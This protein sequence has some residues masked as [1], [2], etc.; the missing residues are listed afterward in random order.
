MSP[1]F[2]FAWCVKRLKAVCAAV[3]RKGGECSHFSISAPATIG[4]ICAVE[5]QLGFPLP[6]NLRWFAENC[7]AGFCVYWDLNDSREK[8]P[9]NL[10]GVSSGGLE[11]SLRELP[12]MYSGQIS[13]ARE[14]FPDTN[15]PFDRLWHYTLCFSPVPNGDLLAIQRQPEGSDSIVYLSHEGDDEH[16]WQMGTSFLDSFMRWCAIGCVGPESWQWSLFCASSRGNIDPSGLISR[17][18]LQWL[19]EGN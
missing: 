9:P 2:D 17:A 16:G 15:S 12:R 1:P 7:S 3:E 18:W 6:S 8:L 11:F 4:S 14:A 5:Q 13:M 19:H 10:R